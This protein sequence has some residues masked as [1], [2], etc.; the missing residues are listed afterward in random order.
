METI[1]TDDIVGEALTS[2][3]AALAGAFNSEVVIF[4]SEMR[5]PLDEAMR[6]EVEKLKS[7]EKKPIDKLTVLVETVGGFIET[8]ERIVSVF[9]RHYN[10]VEYIVPNFAYSAGTILVLSGD[11]IY[12]DYYSIL[13]PID[14]QYENEH[15]ELVP[16]MGYL[17]KYKE[18]ME[19][20]NRPRKQGDPEPKAE[21]AYLI[22][23]FDAAK[24][25]HIEQSV[26][27]SRALLKEWLPRHKFKDWVKTETNGLP[28]DD[29]IR[30]ERADQIATVLGDPARWHSHGRGISMLE[31]G[32]DDIKLKIKDFGAD[33]KLNSHVR[34]YYSL[35]VDYANKRAAKNAIHTRRGLRRLG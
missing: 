29:T 17:A 13:G 28:V 4:R 6:E 32:G 21:L 19:K 1:K 15:G 9:R 10:T 30:T 35:F 23:K 16:G 33:P 22:K 5:P 11:E 27:H 14:P 20:I 18:L 3:N 8:V 7:S 26:E 12:M 24:L 25:F 34:N 2:A 31:L